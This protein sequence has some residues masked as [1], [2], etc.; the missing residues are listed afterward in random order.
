M[1]WVVVAVAVVLALPVAIYVGQERL[2]FHP[3]PATANAFPGAESVFVQARDGTRRRALAGG[4][5]TTAA[6]ASALAA[7]SPS[8]SRPRAR[9]KP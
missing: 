4:S 3:Q 7:A 9:S 2:I 5:S 6:T 8:S 1:E